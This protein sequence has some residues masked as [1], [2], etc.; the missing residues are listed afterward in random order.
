MVDEPADQTPA[1][2]RAIRDSQSGDLAAALIEQRNGVGALVD[3]D[4]DDHGRLLTW[5]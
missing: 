5:G 1:A 2:L 3:V 4:A